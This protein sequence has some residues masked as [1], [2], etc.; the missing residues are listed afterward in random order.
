MTFRSTSLKRGGIESDEL[1]SLH[2][3]DDEVDS[4]SCFNLVTDFSKSVGLSLGLKFLSVEVFRKALVHHSMSNGY[5]LYYF[6]NG[7]DRVT[8]YCRYRCKCLWNS[9]KSKSGKFTCGEEV[10]KCK[11]RVH[12]TQMDNEDTFQIKG[13]NLKHNCVRACYN[14]NVNSDF[15]AEKYLEFFRDNIDWK[16]TNFQSSVLKELGVHVSYMKCLDGNNNIYPV[17]WAVVEVENRDSWT[18]FLELLASD[19]G[20]V[21]GEGLTF[22]SD[23][24]KGLLDVLNM[25][26]PKADVRFCARHI[27]ANFKLNFNGQVFKKSFWAAAR[28]TTKRQANPH[29]YGVDEE[30]LG[31][32]NGIGLMQGGLPCAHAMCCINLERADPKDF[33]HK[34]YTKAKY[35]LTYEPVVFP[36]PGVKHWEKT[37]LPE[38]VRPPMKSMPGRLKSKRRRNEPGEDVARQVK[39]MKKTNKCGNIGGSGHSRRNCKNPRAHPVINR[40]PGGRLLSKSQWAKEMRQRKVKRARTR[41]R[42]HRTATANATSSQADP[43]TIHTSAP[44]TTN[45][46][47]NLSFTQLLSQASNN[48]L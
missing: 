31:Y 2:G 32:V 9:K 7:K 19:L 46:H 14:R 29:T 24:Q 25:V 23:K 11:F 40:A 17:A 41:E 21:E 42:P 35:Q 5:Y 45:P 8:A 36:M 27:W 39:R 15:L 43:S 6:H 16:L 22:M 13:L 33:V 1:K 10:R 30:S 3:S 38:P 34:A 4:N 28:A 26:I 47:A 18:W 48:L 37:G 20:K 12:A 44:S